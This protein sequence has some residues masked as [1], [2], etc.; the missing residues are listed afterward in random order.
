MKQQD[1]RLP[2]KLK[3]VKTIDKKFV[4]EKTSSIEFINYPKKL[5]GKKK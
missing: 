4:F 2:Q 3:P 5:N 1:N